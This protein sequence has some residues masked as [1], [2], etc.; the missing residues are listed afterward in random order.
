M[1]ITNVWE[2]CEAIVEFGEMVEND[3][4]MADPSSNTYRLLYNISDEFEDIFDFAIKQ[5]KGEKE[6]DNGD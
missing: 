1:K 4:R 5:L 2:L 3:R 6:E